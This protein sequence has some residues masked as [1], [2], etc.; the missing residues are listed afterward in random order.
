MPRK[1]RKTTESNYSHLIVQGINKEYIFQNKEW[2]EEYIKILKDKMEDTNVEILAYCIMDNHAHFL[3]YYEKIEDL[4]S[5]MRK[6]NTTYA[7]RYNKVNK[8]VG[9]VFRDRFFI[10]PILNEKQLCNCLVY[11]HKNPIKAGI[12]SKMQDYRYS[13][14]KEYISKKILITYNG[15]ELVFG[16]K[17]K[18]IEQFKAIH[19]EKQEIKDIKDIIDYEYNVEELLEIYENEIKENLEE[20]Q[21]E[22]GNLLLEI[23]QKCGMSLRE[24]SKLFNINKDK[25]NRYIHKVIDKE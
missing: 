1:A 11:I 13:S 18:Y 10:Q 20:K 8:R 23:R 17:N 4:S 2:K 24:M 14:Y 6:V 15:I 25:L 7:M 16:S 3:I 5:L 21:I 19:N 22:F 12:C 9:F